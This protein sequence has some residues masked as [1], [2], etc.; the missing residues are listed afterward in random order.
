MTQEIA[1]GFAPP[2]PGA[3]FRAAGCAKN[4]AAFVQNPSAGCPFHLA[5]IFA[6][7]NHPL[8][9]FIDAIDFRALIKRG[10]HSGADG[11][12]HSLGVTA[13]GQN[14]KSF[15]HRDTFC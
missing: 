1:D 12:V 4:C 9:A 5:D 14:S 7:L 3:K 13:T 6:P 8:I 15:G 11:C 10:A 2:L